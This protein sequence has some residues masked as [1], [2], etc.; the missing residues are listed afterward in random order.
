MTGIKKFLAVLLALCVFVTAQSIT[1]QAKSEQVFNIESL[2]PYAAKLISGIT[3]LYS[4]F[5]RTV[6]KLIPPP[7]LETGTYD[8]SDE[9]PAEYYTVG[10]AKSLIM[11]DD[12]YSKKYYVA[13]FSINNPAT[14]ILDDL[15][16]SAVWIDDNSGNGG[17]IF[18]SV[19]CVGLSK[20]DVDRIRKNLKDF[21]DESGCR[22][23]NIMSTHTHAGI[24]TMG[25]WGN[26][27]KSGR[28][29]EYMK[30][31]YD[32]IENAVR[33]AYKNRTRGSLYFG[34]AE[35]ETLQYDTRMPSVYS[36][37]LTRLRFVPLNNGT[38]VW[39]LNF[40]AHAESLLRGNSLISADFP[41]YLRERI[42]E[43]TGAE[44]IFFNGAI[45]GL[46]KTVNR[47]QD[48]TISVRQDGE[49]L[50]DIAIAITGEEKLSPRIGYIRQE[51]YVPI[52]NPVM[53]VCAEVGIIKHSKV[54]SGEGK[55]GFSMKTELNFFDI[56][57]V[58]ILLVPGEIFPELVFG[59]YLDADS[60][61]NCD[62]G[63]NPKPLI[64]IAGFEDLIIFGLANDEIGY[65]I[66]PND[67]LLDETLPFLQSA[68]DKNG[69]TLYEETNC[70]GTKAAQSV[71]D[72]F[73]TMMQQ[74]P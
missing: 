16:A 44:S 35:S 36:D 59:G 23:I 74:A 47:L 15:T 70:V 25:M 10:F 8:I 7:K 32:G 46:I 53:A 13:G 65:I 5:G 37:E 22:S 6:S 43:K 4:F 33:N 64:E 61:A 68:T 27:P 73:A 41:H 39:I 11:P 49:E 12:I 60:A 1:V 3:D 56:G 21:S 66:P 71:A 19:D 54:A 28:D 57:G 63:K 18:A 69:R 42:K 20:Y 45:G 48:T 58:K 9:A 55:L 72:A 29:S 38:E 17:V 51:F 50:A 31:V 40:A 30:I 52:D 24:D 34:K 62:P 2:L 14:G 67:Y 26:I